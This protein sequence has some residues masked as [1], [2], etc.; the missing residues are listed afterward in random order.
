[1]RKV[2]GMPGVGEMQARHLMSASGSN[3][4]ED[5]SGI[6]QGFVDSEDRNWTHT[7]PALHAIAVYDVRAGPFKC[8]SV[9]FYAI[10]HNE[11]RLE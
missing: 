8:Q 11:N 9:K 5:E 3:V 6:P 10:S 1:M 2:G 7:L 4:C